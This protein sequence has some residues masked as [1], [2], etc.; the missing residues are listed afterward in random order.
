[1]AKKPA[2]YI[3]ALTVLISFSGCTDTDEEQ[4][5]E[6]VDQQYVDSETYDSFSGQA[7]EEQENTDNQKEG[8]TAQLRH[9]TDCSVSQSFTA[10]FTIDSLTVTEWEESDQNDCL[11]EESFQERSHTLKIIAQTS[12]NGIKILWLLR[13]RVSMYRDQELFAATYSDQELLNAE[14]I[15]VY[16]KNLK[17]KI[18]TD[19]EVNSTGSE[20]VIATI[21]NRDIK[22]PIEQNNSIENSYSIDS[23]GVIHNE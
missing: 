6:V 21:E 23:E 8:L 19:I 18:Y 9:L 10:P 12:L 15:G 11:S 1:M 20:L 5:Q 16:R 14:S 22:Y 17:E 2:I 4:N 3:F 13:S 7:D